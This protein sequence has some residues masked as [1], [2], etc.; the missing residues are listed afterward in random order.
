MYASHSKL[1]CFDS[2]P[3]RYKLRY[4]DKLPEERSMPLLIGG[5]SHEV[6]ARYGKH[7]MDSGVPTDVSVL[8]QIVR[9]V[10]YGD[11]DSAGGAAIQAE[12]A[13]ITERFGETHLFN[14]D[15][16][17]GI[18]ERFPSTWRPPGQWPS[19]PNLGDRHVFVGIVDLLEIG[20]DGEA[21]ITDY[22]TNWQVS[23]QADAES[24]PQLK[25]YCWLIHS[26][27][28]HFE[29]FIV[30][31]D[32]VRHG[33]I[34]TVE[35]DLDVVE[36][37]EHDLLAA[38]DRL[39]ATRAWPATPGSACAICGYTD[40]CPVLHQ[41]GVSACG[42]EEEAE[43]MAGQLLVLG[44]RIKALDNALKAWTAINGPI[45]VNGVEL[46]H[47]PS[48]S[49]GITDVRAVVEALQTAKI[50]PIDYISISSTVVK[51]LLRDKA[52]APILEPFVVDKSYTSFR[53][54]RAREGEAS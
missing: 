15:A 18:E 7:C 34:R 26:E 37:T 54:R 10:V 50:D 47:L 45:Q 44:E 46:G 11:S 9:E 53:Q 14:L 28:P 38:V 1:E 17:I 13:D 31:L 51:K 5:A 19:G 24:N 35:Y 6:F 39:E 20:D 32:F 30:N 41:P 48:E 25:R 8:P 23:S 22:K 33:I 49:V 16:I 27:Y 12:V 43:E 2:C 29:K 4:L 21:V 52:I 3:L 40:R 42:S 36:E